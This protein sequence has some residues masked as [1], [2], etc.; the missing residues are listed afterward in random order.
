[1]FP[2]PGDVT[3]E[4]KAQAAAIAREMQGEAS[5]FDLG[6][7]VSIPQDLMMEELH[8]KR[9]RGSCMYLERQ[10]RVQ[11]FT[12]EYPANQ[13][14]SN[15]QQGVNINASQS[16]QTMSNCTGGSEGVGGKQTFHSEIQISQ[17]GNRNPPNVP[18]KSAKVL[19][20]KMSLN[21]GAIAPGYPGPL[22][23]VPYEKFNSTAIPKSYRSPWI[24]YQNEEQIIHRLEEVKN[25]PEIPLNVSY[26]SYNRTPIPFGSFSVFDSL[27][28]PTIFEELQ[29]QIEESTSG[30]E[31]MCQRPSFNRAPRGW[32]M[33]FIPESDD[34]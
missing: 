18:K 5:H 25:P 28:A 17:G 9:N 15:F 23:G 16:G 7:K 27:S 32:S 4:H 2:Y 31:L 11:K 33:K 22:T 8:L 13:V 21:P 12:F 14:N 34:L 6:K 29:A 30:L 19:Q 26:R 20:M 1:M 24:E 10:K 3:K